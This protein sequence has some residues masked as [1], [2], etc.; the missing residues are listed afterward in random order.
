[1]FPMET[2][3]EKPRP[4]SA[5]FSSSARPSAPLCEEKRD[6]PG[7]N[8]RGREGRVQADRA[9][10]RCR[11]SSGPTRRAPCARTSASRRSWRRMPSIPI[12]AKPAEMTQRARVPFASAASRPRGRRRRERRRPRGRRAPGSRRSTGRPARRR[13]GRRRVDG[14]GG[15]GEVGGEDVAEELAADRAAAAR[16]ADHGDRPR[17][18]EGRSEAVDGDVVALVDAAR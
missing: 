1:M 10:R 2:K 9:A 5:A 3:A 14:I 4:R 15:P 13:R 8:G 7:G 12:S 11:G 16:G 17:L 18:E 6:G